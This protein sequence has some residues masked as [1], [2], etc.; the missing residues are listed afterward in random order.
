MICSTAS[1]SSGDGIPNGDG[2]EVTK[3]EYRDVFKRVNADAWGLQEDSKYFNGSTKES[4]YDA[5]YS[6]V[7]TEY[8]RNFTGSYNGKAFLAGYDVYDVK[9]I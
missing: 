8:E 6:V 7:H 1:G 4:P 9:P 3:K 2:T 5:I